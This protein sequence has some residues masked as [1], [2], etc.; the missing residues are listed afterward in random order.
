MCYNTMFKHSYICLYLCWNK[1][2]PLVKNKCGNLSDSNN[3]RPV[4]I[5]NCGAPP[6]LTVAYWTTDPYHPC[7]NY[8][9]SI[10]EITFGCR[11]A[12]LSYHVHK[13]GHETPI[14]IAIANCIFKVFE[15][16]LLKEFCG[17]VTV[18]LALSLDTPLIL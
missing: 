13:S 8:G 9:L 4:A 14:I 11:S 16:I 7:S 1:L 10:P 12:H 5:V 17:H 3:Y 6:W 18:K 15:G 2:V